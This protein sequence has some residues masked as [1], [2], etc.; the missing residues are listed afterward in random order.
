MTVQ[1]GEDASKSNIDGMV[2]ATGGDTFKTRILAVQG[3]I[4][5]KEIQDLIVDTGSPVS[6]VSLQFYET[7]INKTQLQPIKGH[8]I[9]VNG[10][11]LNIKGSVELMITFDIIEITHKFLCVDTKLFLALLG[12]DFLLTNKV[13][14]LTSANCLLIQNVPIIT[15][16]YKRRNN[17]RENICR[18]I[19]ANETYEKLFENEVLMLNELPYATG[20]ATVAASAVTLDA[21]LI[22]KSA[23]TKPSVDQLSLQPTDSDKSKVPNALSLYLA[24]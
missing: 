16:M 10:S 13:D 21:G 11:L 7:I 24:K 6:L 19:S 17:V 20:L 22:A 5:G 2:L 15:H 23:P 18:H 3:C 4:A 12:Y 9:A 8:Y 1:S 14:I